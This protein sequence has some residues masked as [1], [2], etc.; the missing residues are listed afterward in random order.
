MQFNL[1]DVEAYQKAN[2]GYLDMVRNNK[3]IEFFVRAIAFEKYFG[4]FF[5]D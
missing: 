2:D 5:Y 3:S 1:F 4:G